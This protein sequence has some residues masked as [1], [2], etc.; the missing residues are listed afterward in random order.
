MLVLLDWTSSS[1]E[2]SVAITRLKEAIQKWDDPTILLKNLDTLA[3]KFHNMMFDVVFQVGRT[4][5]NRGLW[6]GDNFV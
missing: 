5:M 2:D 1:F 6:S 3:L 4:V